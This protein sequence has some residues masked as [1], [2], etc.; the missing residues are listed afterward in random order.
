MTA[1]FCIKPGSG[2]N[3]G[4]TWL[5]NPNRKKVVREVQK[6]GV[7]SYRAEMASKLMNDNDPSPPMLYSKSVLHNASS[8]YRSKKYIH[9]NPI[10]AL[11]IL[12]NTEHANAIHDIGHL[13]FFVHYWTSEQIQAYKKIQK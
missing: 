4:K 9:E 11:E 1:R 13:P 7:E 5:R 3:C 12:A 8:Q 10:I 2:I 6:K